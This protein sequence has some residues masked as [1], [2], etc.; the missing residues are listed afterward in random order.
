LN[1][2]YHSV[3]KLNFLAVFLLICLPYFSE[4]ASFG[5]YHPDA[6]FTIVI[7]AGHGGKDSGALGANVYE[8]D[9]ALKLALRLGAYINSNLHNVKVLYTRTTD[10]FVPLHKRVQLANQNNADIFFSIHCN[11]MISSPSPVNGTETYVMGL[12]NAKENLNVAK[13]ENKAVLLEQDYSANY[14]GY[15]PNS[16]EGHIILSMFQNAYLSQSL[17]LAQKIEKQF[18]NTAKRKSRGVKQAGFVVLRTTTMPSVLVETGFLTN[19]EEEKYLSSEKGQVYIASAMFRAVKDYILNVDSKT[20]PPVKEFTA[21]GSNNSMDNSNLPVNKTNNPFNKSDKEPDVLIVPELNE[22][23]PASSP[24]VSDNIT[25][26]VQIASSNSPVNLKTSQWSRYENLECLKIG[27]AY[28]CLSE[29]YSNLN[30]AVYQQSYF[31]KNGF[32]DAFIVAFKN[33]K[34][35]PLSEVNK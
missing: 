5:D 8:K 35:I 16:S 11:S 34:K 23:Y 18:S 31:R 4:T 6:G 30:D 17:S 19:T 12:H 33:G 22:V 9:I 10:K 13:R 14:S 20:F 1:L 24:E 28:K 21:R 3:E 2:I 26:R 25:F 7:D 29:K 15:D 27:N 32:S